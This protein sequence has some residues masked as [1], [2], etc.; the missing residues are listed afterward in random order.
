M[1]KKSLTAAF[2]LLPPATLAAQTIPTACS[3]P[4]KKSV[5]DSGVNINFYYADN[6]N[7]PHEELSA[8]PKERLGEHKFL[9]HARKN[10]SSIAEVIM[11]VLL[12]PLLIIL[13]FS[14]F[15]KS[16]K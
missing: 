9:F 8:S 12:I 2:R 14:R 16:A 1:I 6:L 10:E 5:S 15:T 11:V 13:L 4:D 3:H 7:A